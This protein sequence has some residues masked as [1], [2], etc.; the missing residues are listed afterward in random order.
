MLKVVLLL[1]YIV[2]VLLLTGC[3]DDRLVKA[4]QEQLERQQAELD[5]L[6]KAVSLLGTRPPAYPYQSPSPGA[7]DPKI[8]REA[9]RKGGERFA[10]GDFDAALGYYRDALTT[11]PKNAQANL[12]LAR[13]Y[14]A[15]GDRAQA[16]A[17]Y[18]IAANG[19]GSEANAEAV[20]E[21]RAALSRL[22][23]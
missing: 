1:V 11:C 2:S 4:N 19:D 9:T 14:E 10:A 20:H 22:G 21:A 5:Q 3:F 16:V 12:N 15:V 18:R 17:H 8:L 7:C 13:T 23:G 6:K